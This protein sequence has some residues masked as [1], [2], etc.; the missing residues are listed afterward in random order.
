MIRAGDREERRARL[1]G[2][3][4][5]EQGLPRARR[6]VQEE[7]ALRRLD[8]ELRED[9]RV[10]HRQLDHLA[11]ALDL[12]LE[13]ADILVGDTAAGLLEPGDRLL[14]Q[15]DFGVLGD[16]TDA[17]GLGVDRDLGIAC[18]GDRMNGWFVDDITGNDV[19]LDDRPLEDLAFHHASGVGAELDGRLLGRS[20]DELLGFFGLRLP[21]RHALADAHVG[22]LTGEAVDADRVRV[23][24]LAVGAPDL[25]GGRLRALDLDDV[26]GRA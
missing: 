23:P 7:D 24:V 16:Q 11:D 9:L 20:Q 12:R 8:P 13:P 4:L 18:P 6:A 3:R 2:D 15:F 21:D 10:F 25:G 1:V 22:V 5:R 19:A 26:A 17:V 14:A